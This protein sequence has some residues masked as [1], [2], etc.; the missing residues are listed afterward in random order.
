MKS[1]AITA[2]VALAEVIGEDE[3]KIRFGCS[4]ALDCPGQEKEHECD[5]LKH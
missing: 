5:S 1:T 4:I 3:D 2:E